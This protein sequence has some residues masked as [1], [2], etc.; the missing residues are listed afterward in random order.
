MQWST[1]CPDWEQRIV[2][3][4]SLIPFDPLFPDEAAAA[5]AV[6]KSLR[7]VDIAGSPT[8]GEC[9]EQWV[10]DFVAAIFGAYDADQGKR[11]INEFM[12]LISKK[13]GKSTIAA[14]IMVTAL[15]RN[16]RHLNELMIIA[17]TIK[18][19]GNSFDPAAAMVRADEELRDLLHIQTHLRS[20]THRVTGAVLRVVAA[21]TDTVGGGKAGFV[22]VDELW[23]FG[24]RANAPAMLQEATGGLISRPEGFII[25]LTTQS[26]EPPAG[27]FKSKLE[28]FRDIRDGVV[29]DNK[30]LG[31]LYEMPKAILEAEKHLDPENFYITNPNMGRSVSK[32]WIE[33]RIREIQT[34]G[35]DAEGQDIQTFLAKHLNVQIGLL[36]RRDRWAG[37]DHW[38]NANDN[39]LTL[40]TLIERSE[41]LVAGIDGGGL[42]D[43][44]SIFVIGR[45][46]E[47]P[48]RWMGWVRSWMHPTV[49]ERRKNQ[50]E[51]LLDFVK[52]GDLWMVE[53]LGE[54]IDQLVSVAAE[55][56]ASGRLAM[57][58]LDPA[59]VGLIVDALAEIGIGTT[60]AVDATG[61]PRV[62]AV[63]QGWPLQGAIKTLERKL[64]DGTF[65]HA[66]QPLMG[67][68]ISNAKTEIKGNATMIT[69]QM[70]GSAKIDPLMAAFDGVALMSKNPSALYETTPWDDDPDYRMTA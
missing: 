23:L 5:L 62:H 52:D 20:I 11:L 8:F 48:K 19:A 43:L 33:D 13:N 51:T 56:E 25:Y 50:R 53:E 24:K 26:D 28:Y 35:K 18:I 7:V 2:E 22:L 37:A 41:V 9:C 58:G 65:T 32:E 36:T 67:Y 44:L 29:N 27:V 61:K 39:T 49:L 69:K 38:Q 54:D 68:A 59:G 21:D 16:W 6:F 34:G 64:A 42:D 40:Q 17:P 70:A 66:D 1:A 4:R 55:L 14:G 15:I 30:R 3:R 31:V 10:F 60:E 47:N 46:R 63:S 12:L 45:D 57:I